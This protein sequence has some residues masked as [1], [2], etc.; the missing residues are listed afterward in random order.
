MLSNNILRRKI[1]WDGHILG[2]NCLLHDVIEGQN[3]EL[4]EIARR[5]KHH[6]DDFGKQKKI[7]TVKGGS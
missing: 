1:N 6:L 3:R 2:T 4:K 5:R 7:L